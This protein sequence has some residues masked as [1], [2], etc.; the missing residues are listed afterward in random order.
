MAE[1]VTSPTLDCPAHIK[2]HID[3]L[4][5]IFAKAAVGDFSSKIT[6]PETEDEFTP[7]F[8]GIQMMLEVI[9]EKI[10]A[11]QSLNDELFMRMEEKIAILRS[12]GDGVVVLDEKGRVTFLNAS[13]ELMLGWKESEVVDREW[14]Q[15]VQLEQEDGTVVPQGERPFEATYE[16]PSEASHHEQTFYYVRKSG[17]RF[18]VRTTVS[19]IV[20]NGQKKGVIIVFRD[21][22]REKEVE[23]LK[24][25][26]LSIAAHE[27]RTPLGNMRWTMDMLLSE[28]SDVLP[29]SI[30]SKIEK[31]YQNNIQM[32]GLVNDIL[33]IARLS[34]LSND[35]EIPDSDQSTTPVVREIQSVIKY[36][37]PEAQAREVTVQFGFKEADNPEVL[38]NINPTYFRQ[39]VQNLLSNA[40]K[41]NTMGG[42][43]NLNLKLA[44]E[45][46]CL[47]I[48]DTGIGIPEVDKP[49]IFERFFRAENVSETAIPGTGLGLYVVQSFVKKWGGKLW[50]ESQE[51]RGST[52]H[53][54]FPENLIIPKQ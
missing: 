18:P 52:F 29:Q 7:I 47:E 30:R 46:V 39:V 36:L 44:D 53:V 43:V 21:V 14:V 5:P 35:K 45:G 6:I 4:V 34:K 2:S 19:P 8:V 11:Y 12:I 1:P 42:Q 54:C 41:Y 13:A 33:S 48:Q 15:F 32:I 50:F 26:F 49:H 51:H 25:E 16:I 20:F 10:E 24:D 22:S 31:L 40:I 37:Q 27:L 38:L 23:K 17:R 3:L 28:E 9:N